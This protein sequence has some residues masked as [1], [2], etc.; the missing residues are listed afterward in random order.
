MHPDIA[1]FV[2]RY[3]YF[4]VFLGAFA[5]GESVVVLAGFFAHQGYLHPFQAAL[6]AFLGSFMSDQ[7]MYFLGRRKGAWL[8]AKFPRLAGSLDAVGARVRGREIPLILGFRFVYGIRNV[9]PV[10]LGMHGTKP[11]LFIPL[12]ILSAAV[13][14]AVMTA[15]GYYAGTI[16]VAFFGRV[17]KYEPFIIAAVLFV[18]LV[19][20]L[21]RKRTKP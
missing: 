14:A 8:L 2:T 6:V 4:A 11:A 21:W 5:E 19:F 1:E 10:F 7:A 20:R 16:L 18:F 13:W 3:G 12:N 9:T 17:H 15:A